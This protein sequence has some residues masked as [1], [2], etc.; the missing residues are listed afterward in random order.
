MCGK[1]VAT[2][3]FAPVGTVGK[4]I[5]PEAWEWYWRVVGDGAARS[6][7]LGADRNRRDSDHTVTGAIAQETGI[8]DQAVLRCAAGIVNTSGE[9]LD[10]ECEGNPFITEMPG[11][12]RHV[13]ASSTLVDTYFKLSGCIS[14]MGA[15][16]PRLLLITAAST[17]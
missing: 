13:T 16:T 14:E 6:W 7:I 12:M 3:E 9:I 15:A 10:G 4:P 2:L 5:N 11:M 8:G 17:M 1:K